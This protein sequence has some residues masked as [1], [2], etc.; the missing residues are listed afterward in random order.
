MKTSQ[1]SN[2]QGPLWWVLQHRNCSWI[3]GH[4]GWG[5][6]V[7]RSTDVSLLDGWQHKSL[8]KSN[9]TDL[10]TCKRFFW[11]MFFTSL[12]NYGTP[13][14]GATLKTTCL[15]TTILI[16]IDRWIIFFFLQ[17][18][19]VRT[20]R[21][22]GI[23]WCAPPCSTW[24]WLSRATTGRSLTRVR[25]L[26]YELTSDFNRNPLSQLTPGNVPLKKK[27]CSWAWCLQKPQLDSKSNFMPQ[28]SLSIFDVWVALSIL[29]RPHGLCRIQEVEESDKGESPDKAV[30]LPAPWLPDLG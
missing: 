2:T 25:G 27:M 19:Q 12:K 6:L 4:S 20:L 30:S 14:I 26:A 10:N 29:I 3:H 16:Q 1:C 13:P 7:V 28:I 21:E 18:A 24:V 17:Y 23:W 9:K 8:V 11:N 22:N 5:P 15:G